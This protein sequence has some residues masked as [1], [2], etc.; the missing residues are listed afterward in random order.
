MWLKSFP[1]LIT[2]KISSETF[3]FYPSMRSYKVILAEFVPE[4]EKKMK[5][6]YC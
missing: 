5:T 1:D 3:G 6:R 4:Y 2:A